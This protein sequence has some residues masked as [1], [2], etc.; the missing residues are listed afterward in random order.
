MSWTVYCAVLPSGWSLANATSTY[1]SG[2]QIM[3]NYQK[4]GGATF[5]LEEGQICGASGTGCTV[6]GSHIGSVKFGDRNGEMYDLGSGIIH[7]WVG[8]GGTI[9]YH[10]E[11]VNVSAMQASDLVNAMH[12]LS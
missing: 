10:V 5:H 8:V 2:G 1:N 12:R 6:K 9:V 7:V 11:T 3:A 4:S